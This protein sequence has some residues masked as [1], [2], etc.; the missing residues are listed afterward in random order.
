MKT[1]FSFFANAFIHA[2]IRHYSEKKDT[3]NYF[4][5]TYS[6]LFPGITL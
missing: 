3:M 6:P 2:Q 1:I 5:T 4:V